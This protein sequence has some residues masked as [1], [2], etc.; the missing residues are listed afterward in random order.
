MR[1]KE[2]VGALESVEAKRTSL[3]TR[4]A[5]ESTGAYEQLHQQNEE[6]EKNLMRLEWEQDQ[7]L[8]RLNANEQ[9]LGI[10][11]RQ[12]E[13]NAETRRHIQAV[14]MAMEQ[15]FAAADQIQDTFGEEMNEKASEYFKKLTGGAY[16]GLLFDNGQRINLIQH[17]KKISLEHVSKGTVEQ[18]YLA[19]RLAAADCLSPSVCMPLLLDDTFA[20]YDDARTKNAIALLK[21]S[22]HQ[23][24]IMTCQGREKKLLNQ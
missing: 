20:F 4:L 10:V 13:K 17:G 22:G 6:L 14:R 3:L 8:E 12:W 15:L 24:V 11:Q 16:T 21:D 23:V 1:Y 19:I 7:I 9:Q 5:E 18:V 2:S